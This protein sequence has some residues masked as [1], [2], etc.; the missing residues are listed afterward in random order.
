MSEVLTKTQN[1]LRG[2]DVK[3]MTKAQLMDWMDACA[4]M[5]VSVKAAKA[6]RSWKRAREAAEVEL[7]R[8]QGGPRK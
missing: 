2:R 8:R 7:A 1:S 6:R 5:E 3:N 4:K